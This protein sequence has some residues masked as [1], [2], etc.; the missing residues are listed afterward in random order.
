M[1]DG[2]ISGVA[3]LCAVHLIP[4]VADYL[5]PSHVSKEPAAHYVLDEL[6]LSPLITCDMCLGEG[7]G[8]VAPPVGDGIESLR[9]YGDI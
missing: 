5:I 6:G 7:S 4:A 2:F 3:A 8:A 9:R 1:L